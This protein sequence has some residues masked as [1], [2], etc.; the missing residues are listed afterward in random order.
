MSETTGFE[1]GKDGVGTVVVGIDGTPPSM[2]AAAWAAGL[3]RRERARLVLVYVESL[4]SPAYW[5]AVGGAAAADAANEVVTELRDEAAAKLDEMGID[6][7]MLHGKGDP[8]G[9]L[10]EIAKE[11]RADCIIVGRARHRGGLLGSVPKA[12]VTKSDR[13]VVV[14][15]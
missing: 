11:R 1:I 13:P 8:A 7:E 12:L 9:V 3:A 5:S 14:V 15:P 10:E 4:A 6:W 2:H